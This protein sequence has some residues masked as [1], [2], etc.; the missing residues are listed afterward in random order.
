MQRRRSQQARA[1][2]ICAA[3][4]YIVASHDAALATAEVF[5]C[6]PALSEGMQ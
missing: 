6:Q 5:S 1:F 2:A 3:Q 4:P